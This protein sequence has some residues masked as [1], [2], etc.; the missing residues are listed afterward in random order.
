MRGPDD[1]AELIR[2]PSFDGRPIPAFVRRPPRAPFLKPPYP[3]LIDIHGGPSSQSRPTYSSFDFLLLHRLGIALVSPNVRGSTGYGRTY[4]SLDDGPR[5]EDAVKDI[6]ALLDWIATQPDLDKNRVAVMGGSYGGYMVLA[7]LVHFGDRLRAGI[8]FAGFSSFETLLKDAE[9]YSIDGWRREDGDERDPKTLE[10]L[11]SIS[12]LTHAEEIR[13]PL[14]VIHG[15]N[16]PRVRRREAQRIAA[17][18]RKNG[19]PVWSLLLDDE[20]HG[21]AHAKHS[22]Y[23]QGVEVQ[24]LMQ[25]LLGGPR[26]PTPAPGVAT[27]GDARGDVAARDSPP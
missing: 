4:E 22:Y 5:R 27:P 9:P 25:Y 6:G 26:K 18:V 16:D 23:M 14:L 24:F 7:S 15:K 17:A 11:R 8:D 12:P 20:G 10:F 21:I 13:T 1:E 2:Y 3:V 19:V